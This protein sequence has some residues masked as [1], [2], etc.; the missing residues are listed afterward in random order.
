MKRKNFTVS[1][2]VCTNC[3]R[4]GIPIPRKASRAREEGHL[5]ELYCFGCKE[6]HNHRE[7]RNEWD[8]MRFN[9]VVQEVE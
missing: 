5:K 3:G 6:T 7:F 8:E 2:M 9:Q 4:V 1:K